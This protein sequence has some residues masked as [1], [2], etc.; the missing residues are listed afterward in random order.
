VLLLRMI[1][2]SRQVA[3]LPP[4]PLLGHPAPDFTL[5]LWNG[6]AGQRIHLASLRG[7]PVVVNFWASWCDACRQEGPA[8]VAV[9]HKYGPQGVVFIGVAFND[10]QSAGSAFLRQYGVTFPSGS[11]STG[12]ITV[13]Y[14]IPAV[15]E[16]VF[17]DPK[18]IVRSHIDGAVDATTLDEQIQ[19]LLKNGS[20]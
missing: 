11:D 19:P 17:I 10:T 5:S 4:Y 2:A 9:A 18:G 13:A 6:T 20:P 14:G 12:E 3:S 7:H 15:P 1:A 16:T 8:L